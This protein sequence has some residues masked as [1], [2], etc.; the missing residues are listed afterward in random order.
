M[1]KKKLCSTKETVK[2]NQTRILTT[3]LIATTTTAAIMI[4]AKRHSD[5][6]LKEHDLYDTYYAMDE[7]E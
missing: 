5:A 4:R 1:L 2:R 6:F 7:N 3:A